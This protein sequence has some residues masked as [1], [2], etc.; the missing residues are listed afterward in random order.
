M[1]IPE[2]TPKPPMRFCL[3]CRNHIEKQMAAV[4]GP[5]LLSG[6]LSALREALKNLFW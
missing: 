6:A 1:E 2:D 3:K 4:R 5:H